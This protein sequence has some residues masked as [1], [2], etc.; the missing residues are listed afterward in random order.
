MTH[1]FE[2]RFRS[3]L[4]LISRD[5]CKS[6]NWFRSSFITISIFEINISHVLPHIHVIE[7][8]VTGIRDKSVEVRTIINLPKGLQ[9][10][11]ITSPNF[12]LMFK[13]MQVSQNK[14]VNT[15]EM[16]HSYKT[17]FFRELM[18]VV[19]YNCWKIFTIKILRYKVTSL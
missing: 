11:S 15:I 3:T 18:Q 2:I 14:F 6:P 17:F 12:L 7:N 19:W 5:N 16:W 10:I 13:S 9:G 8:D 1:S 4:L